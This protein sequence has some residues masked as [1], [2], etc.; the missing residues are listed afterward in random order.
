MGF[1]RFTRTKRRTLMKKP[2]LLNRIKALILSAALIVATSFIPSFTVNATTT[3]TGTAHGLT[4]TTDGVI[5][6]YNEA[7]N[8][9]DYTNNNVL[10]D[11]YLISDSLNVS[12]DD[13]VVD[14]QN[15]TITFTNLVTD[16]YMKVYSSSNSY[17]YIFDGDCTIDSI[18][19]SNDSDNTHITISVTSNSSLSYTQWYGGWITIAD[20]VTV[21]LNNK[22]LYGPTGSTPVDYTELFLSSQYNLGTLTID[23]TQGNYN[24]YVDSMTSPVY[25]IWRLALDSDNALDYVDAFDFDNNG[26]IDLYYTEILNSNSVNTILQAS[27]S[28][29]LYSKTYNLETFFSNSDFQ[30][31]YEN[32]VS[33]YSSVEFILKRD[34][35]NGGNSGDSG[36][37]SYNK[38]L[39][40][41]V[42]DISKGSGTIVFKE[43][44]ALPKKVMKALADNPN[45]TLNFVFEHDGVKY[46]ILIPG[47]EFAKYY[48]ESIEWYGHLWLSGHFGNRAK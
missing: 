1:V 14:T 46:D 3:I 4:I 48:D 12:Y 40:N 27:P 35:G 41:L 24:L 15:K 39:N 45:V 29:S 25:W 2:V 37:E 28:S 38:S 6:T 47:K 16:R 13:I 42:N 23:V 33:A 18:S 8:N 34:G 7:V 9:G 36:A 30:E 31:Y 17:T 44:D 20:D 10:C 22:Q 26:S 5:K 43:G 21:D 19:K 32:G 11:I